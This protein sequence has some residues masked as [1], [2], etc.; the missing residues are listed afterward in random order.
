[1]SSRGLKTIDND[2]V[3][4]RTIAFS[5]RISVEQANSIKSEKLVF[6]RNDRREFFNR[7]TPNKLKGES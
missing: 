5:R 3:T 2:D 1:M 4:F 7:P 6:Q